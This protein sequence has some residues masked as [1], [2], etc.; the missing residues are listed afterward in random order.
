MATVDTL[1][2]RIQADMTD[3]RKKLNQSKKA[4]DNSVGSQKRSFASLGTA[5][6]GVIGVVIAGAVA[7]FGSNMVKMASAV[8]EME[9]KSSV[10]FG[11]F[12]GA[13]RRELEEFGNNVGRATSQLEGMA[14]SV[15]DTFVPLGFA[16]GEA[17]KLSVQLTKLAVDTASF[18]NAKDIPRMMAFQSALVGN[19]EA[20]RRFGIVITE[21]ELKAELQRMGIKK[22]INLVTAQEKVQAR[23]NLI[24]AGTVDAQGDAIRTAGSFANRTKGLEGGLIELNEVAIKPL[25]PALASLVADLTRVVNFFK[26]IVADTPDEAFENLTHRIEKQRQSIQNLNKNIQRFIDMGKGESDIVKDLINTRDALIKVLENNLRLENTLN[27][28]KKIGIEED[29]INID[30]TRKA[31]SENKK[32]NDSIEKLIQTTS[33]NNLIIAG[34]SEETLL[35]TKTLMSSGGGLEKQQK[36]LAEIIPAYLQSKKAQDEFKK[37]VDN[38][39]ATVRNMRTE[40]EKLQETLD[41]L[42][43]A[44]N[45]GKISSEEFNNAVAKVQEQLFFATTEGKMFETGIESLST[46]LS[47]TFVNALETGKLSLRDLG[48]VVKEVMA[49]MARDFLKAQ[50]RA[51]LLKTVLNAFGGSAGPSP[52][53]GGTMPPVGDMTAGGGT[54]QAKRPTLVGE[55]GP[56]LFIPSTHGVVKNN[57][58]TKNL[59]GSSKP[60]VVNQNINISTG[61]AYMFG[62]TK[63]FLDSP[64]STSSLTYKV[65]GSKFDSAGTF[66]LNRKGNTA[67]YGGAS[68]ITVMEVLA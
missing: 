66:Y 12:V 68:S 28:A 50:I 57:M 56:E 65:Q 64:S 38:G 8:E 26:E 20:V 15:Q 33:E 9:A 4:V 24:I 31:M 45:A 61:V 22:N 14:S 43:I 52:S 13:V 23:L 41:N 60:V 10:V 16:R 21:T 67:S 25:L 46:K 32:L 3:L 58:D 42:S 1:L 39:V 11:E 2:V 27:R 63:I 47:D 36:R 6:K 17:A 48:N 54:V 51:M 59:M 7:R 18:N 19:H 55:R 37:S 62:N 49:E 5:V 29:L 40:E 34:A 35:F 44:L 30:V 53:I